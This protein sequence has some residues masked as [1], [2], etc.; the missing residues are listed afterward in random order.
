MKKNASS[1]S[2]IT[3]NGG[4]TSTGPNSATAIDFPSVLS[5][6]QKEYRKVES[7]RQLWELERTEYKRT[8]N[9]LE[10]SRKSHERIQYDLMRRVK[11]LELV[12]N[13]ER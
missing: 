11:M 8:I 7:D 13:S 10:G 2:S 5:F 6:L 1:T 12:L 3:M 9:F 4:N